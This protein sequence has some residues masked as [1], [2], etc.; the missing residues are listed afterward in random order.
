MKKP[1]GRRFSGFPRIGEVSA[2]RELGS[3]SIPIEAGMGGGAALGPCRT[4]PVTGTGSPPAKHPTLTLRRPRG[5]VL[6]LPREGFPCGP[7]AAATSTRDWARPQPTAAQAGHVSA[8]PHAAGSRL[9]CRAAAR[10]L[11]GGPYTL[12]ITR[13]PG[14]HPPSTGTLASPPTPGSGSVGPPGAPQR[15]ASV[16]R[17]DALASVV[18]F[19][20]SVPQA[21]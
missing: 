3:N 1:V 2:L 20:V 12:P 11:S 9:L 21:L 13:G 10:G 19:P 7:S 5:H 16:L 6:V 18:S 15:P 4:S 17:G 8:G 14:S